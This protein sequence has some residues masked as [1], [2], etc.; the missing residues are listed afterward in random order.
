MK[1]VKSNFINEATKGLYAVSALVRNNLA[2]QELFFAEAGSMLLQ[3]FTLKMK[4]ALLSYL[5]V[6]IMVTDNFVFRTF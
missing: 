1:M 4:K 5:S 2:G 6:R 3:V